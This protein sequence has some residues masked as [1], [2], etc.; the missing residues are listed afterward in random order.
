MTHSPTTRFNRPLFTVTIWVGFAIFLAALDIHFVSAKVGINNL[1]ASMQASQ[2]VFDGFPHWRIYQS[3]ILGPYLIHG[4]EHLFGLSPFAAY[5]VFI[6]SCLFI[7]KLIVIRFGLRHT[8]GITPALLMLLSQSLL[9][10][11]LLSNSWLYPWD[12]SGLMLSTLFVVMVLS[13]TGWPWFLALA[14]F[15]F[16]NRESAIFICVWLFVQG[17]LG[18]G[19]GTGRKSPNIGMMAAAAVTA[20]SG[21]AVTEWLRAH[22]LIREIGPELWHFTPAGTSWFH[23]QLKLNLAGFLSS[24]TSTSLN[25]PVIFYAFPLAGLAMAATIGIRCYPAYTALCLAFSANLICVF[26]FG[27]LEESRVMIDIIPFFSIFLI[28]IATS[29]DFCKSCAS[30]RVD[31]SLKT[32]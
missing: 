17:L 24:L 6:A 32:R 20:L 15:A 14:A 29:T 12:I 18:Y 7:T 28:Y 11:M 23:W 4:I 5:L 27:I 8:D 22:L 26:L 3:R 21:L 31:E 16:L 19:K 1:F 30:A 25:L 13:G 2:G 9:F 10:A